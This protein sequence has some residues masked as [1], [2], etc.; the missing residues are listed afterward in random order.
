MGRDANKVILF[1]L[2]PK[3]VVKI[4]DKGLS[5]SLV[6]IVPDDSPLPRETAV[7]RLEPPVLQ[8]AIVYL[9]VVPPDRDDVP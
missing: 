6:L 3:P 2:Y 8:R 9:P 1:L 5:P 7:L 4:G